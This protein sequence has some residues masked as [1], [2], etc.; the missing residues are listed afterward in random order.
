MNIIFLDKF[1]YALVFYHSSLLCLSLISIF[2]SSKSNRTLLLFMITKNYRLFIHYN[3]KEKNINPE[4]RDL[5]SFFL[6]I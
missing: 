5:S 6:S 4:K 3:N 2:V 1:Y